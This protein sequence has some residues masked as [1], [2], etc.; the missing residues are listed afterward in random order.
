[1]HDGVVYQKCNAWQLLSC[2][3]STASPRTTLCRARGH[4][5][6]HLMENST[7]DSTMLSRHDTDPKPQKQASRVQLALGRWAYVCPPWIP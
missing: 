1:M 2:P 3:E 5:P 4:R 6:T 7:T